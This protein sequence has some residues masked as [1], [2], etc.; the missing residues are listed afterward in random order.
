VDVT[1]SILDVHHG[2]RGIAS[3]LVTRSGHR[4]VAEGP[5]VGGIGTQR[6]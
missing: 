3:Q 6:G 1:R 4:E 2:D 5:C